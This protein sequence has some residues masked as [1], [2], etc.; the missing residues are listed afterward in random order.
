MIDDKTIWTP[1]I[2]V[3]NSYGRAKQIYQ[4]DNLKRV[5]SDGTVLWDPTDIFDII[6]NVDM[7]KFPF[8]SHTCSILFRVWGYRQGE[9]TLINV[10]NEVGLQHYFPSNT[11]NLRKTNVY[12]IEEYNVLVFE[13]NIER[14]SVFFIINLILPIFVLNILNICAF[15]LP[16]ESGERIGFSV[17]V[18]LAIA[19]FL[20]ISSDQLP[21][22]SQPRLPS[23][24]LLLFA[25]VVVSSMIV[26][27]IV[28]SLRYYHSDDKVPVSTLS[29]IFV[30]VS[31]FIRCHAVCN[32]RGNKEKYQDCYRKDITWRDVAVEIDCIG[33]IFTSLLII[34]I[35]LLFVV[36]VTIG[37][38]ILDTNFK[39]HLI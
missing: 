13:I 6:C 32:A 3:L 11:W 25:E 31:R 18:L 21:G 37:L 33:V 30:K 19:V 22:T 12:N 23:L 38:P 26:L 5:F 14:Q 7:S 1:N 34:I 39:P 27:Q 10:A 2:V 29:R 24:S 17:T 15:F 28:C 9:V 16:P 35:N 4:D 8:D 20:T 36:D